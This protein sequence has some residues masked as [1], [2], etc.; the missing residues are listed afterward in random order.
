MNFSLRTLKQLHDIG[1]REVVT[2]G[3]GNNTAEE[4]GQLINE[5]ELSCLSARNCS[6]SIL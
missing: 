1:Y 4:F 3:F 6:H 5:A 2:A